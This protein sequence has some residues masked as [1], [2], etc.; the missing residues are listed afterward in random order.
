MKSD[1]ELS[2]QW[3]AGRTPDKRV[4]LRV[5]AIEAKTGGLFGAQRSPSIAQN[6][7]DPTWLRG[8]VLAGDAAWHDKRVAL[9]LPKL[10]L[11]KVAVSD[12]VAL[13]VLGDACICIAEVPRSVAD[14]E[15]STWLSSWSCAPAK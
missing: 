6:V 9:L 1:I 12:R 11:P 8:T 7:P 4:A 14:S 3:P 2:W 10:E 5:E 15:L 13:A